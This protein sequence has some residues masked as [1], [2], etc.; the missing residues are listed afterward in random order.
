MRKIAI[1]DYKVKAKN[2][3]GETIEA[4]YNVKES[5]VS[6]LFQPELQL[7]ATQLLE[8]NKL[9]NKINDTKDGF[10]LLEDADYDKL[11]LALDAVK[12]LTRNDVEFVKRILEAEQVNVKEK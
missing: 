3:T 8:Q 7:S 5:L 2:E 11:K 12:G 6:V 9:A 1:S 10:V 4:P